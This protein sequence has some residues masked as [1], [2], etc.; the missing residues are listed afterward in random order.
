MSRRGIT[1]TTLNSCLVQPRY[2]CRCRYRYRCRNHRAASPIR[3]VTSQP[4]HRPGDHTGEKPG[5]LI[6]KSEGGDST[7]ISLPVSLLQ[8]SHFPGANLFLGLPRTS[9]S[10]SPPGYSMA[11]FQPSPLMPPAGGVYLNADQELCVPFG[12]LHFEL[13]SSGALERMD[14]RQVVQGSVYYNFGSQPGS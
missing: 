6:C 11:D 9:G 5:R 7:P 2:C 12:G 1:L 10:G 8:S 3:H 4:G 13:L 14:S